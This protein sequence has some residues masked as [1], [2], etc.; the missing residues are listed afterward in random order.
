MLPK[1]IL[2]ATDFSETSDKALDYAIDFAKT[3]GAT[4][5]VVHAFQTPLYQLPVYGVPDPAALMATQDL[6]KSLRTASEEALARTC[7]SRGDRGV[8]ITSVLREGP[9]WEQIN[10]VA[11]EVGAGMIVIG[12][13]GRKGLAHAL[14]GS[15]SEKVVRTATLPVLTIRGPH[16]S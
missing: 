4:V 8:K 11:T 14:L 15:V 12:T 10:E 7:E 2:V 16:P 3:V 9:A 13:H 1:I 5:T 6:S